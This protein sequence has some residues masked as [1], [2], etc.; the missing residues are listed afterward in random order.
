MAF[1]KNFRRDQSGTV[2]STLV[3]IPL[4]A[5]FLITVELIVAVNYRNLDLSL[6]QSAASVAAIST[7]VPTSDEVISFS[8]SHSYEELRLVI[9][10]RRRLLPSL[11]PLWP[12]FG[13]MGTPSTE[14]SGVAVMERDPSR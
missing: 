6:A 2:E 10:H 5:L 11:I 14:V 13:R 3:I 7:V 1:A 8:S 4:M 12:L 9:S